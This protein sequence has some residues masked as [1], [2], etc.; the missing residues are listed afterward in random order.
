MHRFVLFTVHRHG[1][2]RAAMCSE[3]TR[4]IYLLFSYGV[5][6][7]SPHDSL[8]SNGSSSM[9]VSNYSS[10]V[11][12]IC[13]MCQTSFGF[14][15]TDR[16]SIIVTVALLLVVLAICYAGVFCFACRTRTIVPDRRP[17]INEPTIQNNAYDEEQSNIEP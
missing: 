3:K 15:S 17:I 5:L 13:L 2:V 12:T 8:M 14:T 16:R 9:N 1:F 4:F 6:N 7:F 10:I 11:S